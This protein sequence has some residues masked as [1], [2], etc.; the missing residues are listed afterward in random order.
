MFNPTCSRDLPQVHSIGFCFG[1]PEDCLTD[2]LRDQ[3]VDIHRI[4]LGK[5]GHLD[6]HGLTGPDFDFGRSNPANPWKKQQPNASE[7]LLCQ[8][9]CLETHCHNQDASRI[10]TFQVA[11]KISRAG[12]L[13]QESRCGDQTASTKLRQ[14]PLCTDACRIPLCQPA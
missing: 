7:I 9:T 13:H 2:L 14:K 4:S 3:V 1:T 10:E 5:P 12:W 6:W 8:P 11:S